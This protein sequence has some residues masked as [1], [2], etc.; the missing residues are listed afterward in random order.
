MAENTAAAPAAAAPAAS[1]DAPPKIPGARSD[2]QARINELSQQKAHFQQKAEKFGN[3]LQA[4][5]Q[6]MAQIRGQLSARPAE[7]PKPTAAPKT[8]E[9]ASDDFLENA[10]VHARQNDQS[11]VLDA[12]NR[13][14][15]RREATRASETAVAKA[16]KDMERKLLLRDIQQQIVTEF[17]PE[18]FDREGPL[19]QA[20]DRYLREQQQIYGDEHA[21]QPHRLYDAFAHASLNTRVKSERQRLKELEQENQRLKDAVSLAEHGGIAPT[22]ARPISDEV[23][24]ALKAGKPKEAARKLAITASLAQQVKNSLLPNRS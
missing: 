19:F 10:R 5:R 7:P 23:K 12:V 11:D 3:E 18:A 8:W 6:E 22:N 20:A 14:L 17:G 2:V 24:E 15:S 4:L 1:P 13:E 21:A 9:Q 16:T